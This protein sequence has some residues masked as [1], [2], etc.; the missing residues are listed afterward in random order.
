[1]KNSKSALGRAFSLIEMLVVIAII[2]ILAAMVMAALIHAKTQAQVKKSQ[3]EVNQ[4]ASAIQSYAAD[5]SSLPA[6]ANAA[7]AAANAPTGPEDFTYGTANLAPIKGPNGTFLA[8]TAKDANGNDLN[9]QANNSEVMAVLLDVEYYSNNPAMPTVN[10]GH[11]KNPQ[12]R[13]LLDAAMVSSTNQPGVGPDLVYR[14]PWLQPYFITLDLN[15]DEKA[16][17]GFYRSQAISE[18]P[19]APGPSPKPGLNGLDP[20]AVNGK[21]NY[22]ASMQVMVWSAGPDKTISTNDKATAGPNKDN[23]LNW[24]Q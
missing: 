5:Y 4:I 6:S 12:R 1:M 11:V 10:K 23:I 18:D 14:D 20:A 21:P 16:R 2:S 7:R 9:Y 3:L 19:N 24:K 15:A 17:D 13:R 8:V 22:E